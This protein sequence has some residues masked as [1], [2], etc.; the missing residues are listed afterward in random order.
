MAEHRVRVPALTP[1]M[2]LGPREARHLQV[3]RLRPGDPVRVF[4]GQ[5]AEAGATVEELDE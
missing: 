2:T 1:Q 3:L 5:G 4:D